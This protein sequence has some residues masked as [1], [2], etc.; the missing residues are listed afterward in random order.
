LRGISTS[1]AALGQG[2]DLGQVLHDG[3][4]NEAV[5]LRLDPLAHD[6]GHRH[7]LALG[8]LGL[9]GGDEEGDVLTLLEPAQRAFEGRD[10]RLLLRVL[11]DN[12]WA[13]RDP[14]ANAA[15][16]HDWPQTEVTWYEAAAYCNWLSKMEN[17]PEEQW[18]Y[19]PN[20]AGE[21]AAGMRPR[22]DYLDCRGYR[23]PTEAEW[24][25][26]CRAGAST[27]YSFGEDASYLGH[28][29]VDSNGVD[30]RPRPVATRMPN[31]FGLFDMHG[32]AAEWCQ[33]RSVS[34]GRNGQALSASPGHP[35]PINDR[36]RLAVRGATLS[37]SADALRCA[38]RDQEEPGR[39]RVEIGFRVVRTFP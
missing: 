27:A 16:S 39:R 19:R 33:G 36:Q 31:D 28:Y 2:S 18:C 37:D 23:L 29:A 20:E 34:K 38:A 10:R 4:E 12:P 14:V 5:R 17:L 26:A 8:P 3:V 24:E 1:G 7:E 21:Y 11:D 35:R 25:Y 22:P 13:N 9:D 6:H 15:R 30:R 32:N